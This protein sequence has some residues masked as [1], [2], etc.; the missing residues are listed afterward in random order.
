MQATKLVLLALTALSISPT[1]VRAATTINVTPNAVSVTY[2]KGT[3]PG[4]AQ[5]V[6]VKP[7]AGSIYFTVDPSVP[8]WLMVSPTN[9]SPTSA[10]GTTVSFTASSFAASLGSGVYTGTVTLHATTGANTAPDAT[11]AVTLTVKN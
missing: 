3:G 7:A 1:V 4:A 10:A 11:I 9:G 6:V 8:N 5:T 2:V